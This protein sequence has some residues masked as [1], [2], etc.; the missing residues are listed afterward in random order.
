MTED[1]APETI[2]TIRGIVK[3]RMEL[4]PKRKSMRTVIKVVSEVLIERVRVSET[5]MFTESLRF[6]L[7]PGSFRFSRILSKMT[8]VALIE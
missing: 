4:T 5:A 3:S 8:M 7:P 2:P 6:F 1:Q